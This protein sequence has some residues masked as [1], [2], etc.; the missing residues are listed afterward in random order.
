MSED[1]DGVKQIVF[2]VGRIG[3]YHDELLAGG[4]GQGI[5]KNVMDGYR[6]LVYNYQIGDEIY[7]FGFSRGAFTVRSLSGLIKNCG[8][9]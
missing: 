1:P 3:S 2:M 9:I 6:F 4:L 8:I 7:L 5:E